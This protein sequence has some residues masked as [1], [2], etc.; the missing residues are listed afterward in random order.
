MDLGVVVG[1]GL[2][3][4]CKHIWVQSMGVTGLGVG[5]GMGKGVSI[6]PGIGI[7]VSED[8][9]I[10]L[11]CSHED[12]HTQTH[13]YSRSSTAMTTGNSGKFRPTGGLSP[14]KP[15]SRE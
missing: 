4:R 14:S 9:G 12:R 8:A 13:T 3:T 6:G 10:C 15:P 5:M 7:G 1:R 2:G 11:Q